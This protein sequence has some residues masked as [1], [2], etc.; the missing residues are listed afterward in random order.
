[1]PYWAT[2]AGS[3]SANAGMAHVKVNS[4]GTFYSARSDTFGPNR[5]TPSA[6]TF[7]LAGVA[8]KL[9]I[10]ALDIGYYVN[11]NY[12]FGSVWNIPASYTQPV[13]TTIQGYTGAA[14]WS[15]GAVFPEVIEPRNALLVGDISS[16][17]RSSGNGVAY[18]ISG[19]D[20]FSV[21]STAATISP[22]LTAGSS[23]SAVGAISA[24]GASYVTNT[25]YV[26]ATSLGTVL[27][28]DG[29]AGGVLPLRLYRSGIANA[30]IKLGALANGFKVYDNASSR[31]ITETYN[32]AS[33]IT[34]YLGGITA[35]ATPL[36]GA[37]LPAGA[38]GTNIAGADL[39]LYAGAGTGAGTGSFVTINAP[40]VAAS[41][42]TAQSLAQVATFSA[43]YMNF[44]KPMYL[45]SGSTK[46]TSV[47]HG[48]S[49]NLVAGVLVVYDSSVTA[50]TRIFLT[51]HVRG[52]ITLPAVYDAATR[53]PGVSFTI[54]SSNVVDTSTVEY[55]M[56]EP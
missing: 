46:T 5:G 27:T 23:I 38:S 14:T 19:A 40:T 36:I 9:V 32:S 44:L 17:F 42:S 15:S 47:R 45:G 25:L 21:T 20:V 13:L 51:T 50:N 6:F 39:R 1:M 41:S 18:D 12:N 22:A 2:S 30:D 33:Q 52:T 34:M 16:G 37:I 55:L 7:V 4:P 49:T 53:T 10:G 48:I 29:G 8:R 56:I 28:A 31:T 11:T 26:G 43:A 54:T 35:L 3:V 24:G